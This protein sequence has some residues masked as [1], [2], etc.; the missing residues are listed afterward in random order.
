MHIFHPS[1]SLNSRDVISRLLH[2][3]MWGGPWDENEIFFPP[4]LLK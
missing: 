4:V 3:S 2:G 1:Q